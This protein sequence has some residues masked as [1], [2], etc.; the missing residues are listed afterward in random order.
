[1]QSEWIKTTI[2]NQVTLQRGLDITKAQQ[3]PGLIPVISSGG[4]SSFHDTTTIKGPGVILGRKG[5]VGSVYFIDSDYWPH[6]TTLWVK[7]FNNNYPRFVYYFFKWKAPLLA[8]LDVGSANPTLNRNHVHPVEVDWPPL[9]EQESIAHILGSLDDKI[10]L[11]RQM[12][13][14]LE[15]MAQALFKSWFVDFDP[16][17]DNALAA[18]NP[19]PDELQ[20][21]ATAREALGDAR[22]PLPGDI[23]ALFPAA[24]VWTEEMGWIP[25]GWEVSLSGNVIDVRDGTHDSPKPSD[26]GYPL[27]TSR[28][29]TSGLLQLS[30]TYLISSNDYE[31]INQR[32][33]VE[34]G[35]ILLT[36]IGTVG[37]PYLVTQNPVNFAIKNIGLF[38]T[39]A[40]DEYRYYFYY[41]LKSPSM[42]NYLEARMAGTTQKYL[43]LKALRNIDFLTPSKSLL[44]AFNSYIDPYINKVTRLLEENENLT[45]LRD[46]LLPKLLSGE[47]RIPDAEKLVVEVI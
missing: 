28:H 32:S 11:N 13:A 10:E 21:K 7:Q 44:S 33:N 41:L 23:A 22:K 24:F 19:I 1:M 6:D 38:R 12:N 14:T 40:A 3:R 39:S 31:K 26:T 29:I 9:N 4:V 5:I 18:G 16:V 42:Q 25:E 35:D 8:S 36:M 15:A 45:E 37:I 47:L 34:Y 20:D 46:T 17:L 2:G 43:S 30:D 27:V